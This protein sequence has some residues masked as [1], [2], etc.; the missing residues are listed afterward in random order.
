MPTLTS[1]QAELGALARHDDVGAQRQLEPAAEREAFDRGD[2]RLRAVGNRAPVFLHVARH[3]LDRTGLRHFADVGAGREGRLRAGDDQAADF[4]VGAEA[5]DLVGQPR[6][7]VE[8]ERIAHLRPVEPQHD[9]IVRRTFDQQRS[10]AVMGSIHHKGGRLPIMRSLAA[11][12]TPSA[13]RCSGRRRRT[14]AGRW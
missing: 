3:D 14:D 11:N 7:H 2:Q 9:D 10:D 1:G 4:R 6:A 8:I 13:S 12:S 5:R